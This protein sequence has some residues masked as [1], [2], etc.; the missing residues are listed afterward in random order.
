LPL[1]HQSQ[2]RTPGGSGFCGR[3][4]VGIS[5][6]SAVGLLEQ[7]IQEFTGN[8]LGS[9]IHLKTEIKLER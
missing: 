6:A 9:V 1:A 4:R 2:T 3:Y 8:G 7:L 5:D